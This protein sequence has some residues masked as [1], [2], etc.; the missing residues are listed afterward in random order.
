MLN[1]EKQV[2]Q[3][4]WFFVEGSDLVGRRNFTKRQRTMHNAVYMDLRYS[5]VA[6]AAILPAPIAEITV[7]APVTASPPA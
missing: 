6:F 1:P 7:D 3:G 5:S 2:R 4:V